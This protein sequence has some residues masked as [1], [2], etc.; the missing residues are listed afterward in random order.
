[1]FSCDADKTWRSTEG[2]YRR[3]S[4]MNEF[5]RR[6]KRFDRVLQKVGKR[7]KWYQGKNRKIKE[8]TSETWCFLHWETKQNMTLTWKI[9]STFSHLI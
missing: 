5:A 6:K 4:N 8:T 7:T 3:S 9:L 1:M 2:L